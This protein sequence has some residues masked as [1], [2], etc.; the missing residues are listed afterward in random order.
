[1]KYLTENNFSY[2]LNKKFPDLRGVGG[3]K[4]SYD[5][6]IPLENVLIEFQGIYHDGTVSWQTPEQF[7][8]QHEHDKTNLERV[9]ALGF[10]NNHWWF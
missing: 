8:I 4:L 3:G 9:L 2:E 10:A 1:M 6:Y 5:F 7:S